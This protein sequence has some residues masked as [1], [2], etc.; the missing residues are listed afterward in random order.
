MLNRF[1]S[2][3][4][5][6][7]EPAVSGTLIYNPVNRST[8][9]DL[10][11]VTVCMYDSSRILS[12]VIRLSTAMDQTAALPPRTGF[13]QTSCSTTKSPARGTQSLLIPAVHFNA[14]PSPE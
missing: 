9:K 5:S 3:V 10:H 8:V 11:L 14:T 13:A 2:L 1:I 4:L 6:L 12:V 7:I